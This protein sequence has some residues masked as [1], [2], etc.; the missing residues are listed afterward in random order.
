MAHWD[1]SN[2]SSSAGILSRPARSRCI[3]GWR[4]H[5]HYLLRIPGIASR[6]PAHKDGD[7]IHRK[8]LMVRLRFSPRRKRKKRSLT[9]TLRQLTIPPGAGSFETLI[10]NVCSMPI[11]EGRLFSCP[12]L[13]GDFEWGAGYFQKN[14]LNLFRAADI[15]SETTL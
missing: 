1:C 4:T 10:L 6:N 12:S 8:H 14:F 5:S 2:R 9:E 15:V 7:A 11:S 13:Y 3:S